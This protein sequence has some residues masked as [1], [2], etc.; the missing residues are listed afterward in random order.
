MGLRRSG[1]T[2]PNADSYPDADAY[3]KAA[4]SAPTPRPSPTAPSFDVEVKWKDP[5]GRWINIEDTRWSVLRYFEASFSVESANTATTDVDDFDFRLNVNPP[6]TGF[7]IVDQGDAC[8]NSSKRAE[9]GLISTPKHEFHMIRCH[10][11]QDRNTGMSIMAQRRSDRVFYHIPVTGSFDVAYHP[12]MTNVEYNSDYVWM[13]VGGIYTDRQRRVISQSFPLTVNVWNAVPEGVR[14]NQRTSRVDVRVRAVP[15]DTVCSVVALACTSYYSSS[16]PHLGRI[17]VNIPFPPKEDG[18]EWVP[19][20]RQAEVNTQ[21][22]FYLPWVVA[23]EMGHA[24]GLDHFPIGQGVMQGGYG[25]NG[26]YI[27]FTPSGQDEYGM[28]EVN[29]NHT[30]PHRTP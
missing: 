30:H 26:G 28:R 23:H 7:Y 1:N 6:G 21:R 13:M 12:E 8:D 29:R 22:F 27:S 18:A 14:F 4:D 10:I 15:Y 25:L 3:P 19:T 9:T 2:I 20:Y 11:G 5:A 16:Y 17:D 24:V